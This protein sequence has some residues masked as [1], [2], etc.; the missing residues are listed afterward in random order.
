MHHTSA[1]SINPDKYYEFGWFWLTKWSRFSHFVDNR[2]FHFSVSSH[3]VVSTTSQR[4]FVGG[5]A[6]TESPICSWCVCVFR[7]F[8]FYHFRS[9]FVDISFQ[10]RCFFCTSDTSDL[11]SFPILCPCLFPD[12]VTTEL[13]HCAANNIP[14]ELSPEQLQRH[15]D[16]LSTN[17][18]FPSLYCLLCVWLLVCLDLFSKNK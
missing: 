11:T 8:V 1:C 13:R 9:A 10:S 7:L 3:Q 5:G 2:I 18:F 15:E 4:H 17:F 6:R 16:L 12:S 14:L